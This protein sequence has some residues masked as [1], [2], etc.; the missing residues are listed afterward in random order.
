MPA[1]C[2]GVYAFRPTAGVLPLEG[3]STA[4]HSLAVPALLASDPHVLLRAGE[5]LQ[6]PGGEWC[7]QP[8]GE[9]WVVVP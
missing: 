4:S 5:A 1:A 2:C 8:R 9:A 6:L 7:A 3:A